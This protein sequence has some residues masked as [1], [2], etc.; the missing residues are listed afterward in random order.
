MPTGE[1]EGAK[2]LIAAAARGRRVTPRGVTL[3]A[4]EE[5]ER[6]HTWEQLGVVCREQEKRRGE[7]AE[8]WTR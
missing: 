5:L 4:L 8:P 6:I 2:L 7:A 3:R 1:E